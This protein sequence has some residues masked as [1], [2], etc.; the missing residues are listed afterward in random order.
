M[1][2]DL[3]NFVV[4]VVVVVAIVV[5]LLLL[6]WLPTVLPICPTPLQYRPIN[7]DRALF[8]IMCIIFLKAKI[9]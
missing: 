8:A 4:V 7:A 2:I 3:E 9:L 6:R 1:G 5:I